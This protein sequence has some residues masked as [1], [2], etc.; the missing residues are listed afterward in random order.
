VRIEGV[1]IS[2][3]GNCVGALNTAAL[4]PSCADDRSICSKWRTAGSL[5]GYITLEQADGVK[6]RDLNNKSLCSLLAGESALTCPRDGAGQ[7]LYKGDYCSKDGQGG[8]CGD[9]VW[10]AATFAASAAKI[11][12][13]TGKVDGCSGAITNQDAGTDASSDASADAPNDAPDAD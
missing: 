2:D 3:E 10:L 8:S 13:G 1:T 6:I 11:F 5:G 7:I 9:S 4:D 12:D